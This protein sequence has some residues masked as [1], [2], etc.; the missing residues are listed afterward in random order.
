MKKSYVTNKLNHVKRAYNMLYEDIFVYEIIKN[1]RNATSCPLLISFFFQT[2]LLNS[3]CNFTDFP[4]CV[5]IN[6][7]YFDFLKFSVS[8]RKQKIDVLDTMN[9]CIFIKK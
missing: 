8:E 1:L 5:Y 3:E 2:A 9:I 6:S 7:L 4:Y